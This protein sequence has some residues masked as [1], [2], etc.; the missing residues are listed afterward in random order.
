MP[1]ISDANELIVLTIQEWEG[2]PEFDL[3]DIINQQDGS[4]VRERR[5]V[6]KCMR[7]LIEEEEKDVLFPYI[8]YYHEGDEKTERLVKSDKRF[9]LRNIWEMEEDEYVLETEDFLEIVTKMNSGL[10]TEDFIVSDTLNIYSWIKQV[11]ERYINLPHKYFPR[12]FLVQCRKNYTKEKYSY[13][14]RESHSIIPLELEPQ[15]LGEGKYR[16]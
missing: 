12:A 16:G 6:I 10:K 11:K 4:R 15:Y 8:T 9:R 13:I 5:V 1:T 2:L 3:G 14:S 7:C